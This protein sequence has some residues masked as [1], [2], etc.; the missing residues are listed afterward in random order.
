MSGSALAPGRYFLEDV[1]IGDRIETDALTL[2]GEHIDRF[3]DLTGDRFEIHVSEEGAARHGFPARV[4]H[5]LLILSLVDGLK[6]QAAAQFAAVASL[7]WDWKFAAPVFP[8][9]TIRALLTV[10]G[11]RETRR[12][13][14]GILT[15][16]FTVL[17]QRGETVQLGVNTLMVLR[18]PL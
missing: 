11:K 3:A 5:G 4:A 7:G 1:E 15:I 14:R 17:N 16:D 9:D 8:G 6:N 18:R 13:E 2:E 12:P 10:R